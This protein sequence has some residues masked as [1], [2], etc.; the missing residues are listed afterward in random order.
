[1]IKQD[2]NSHTYVHVSLT[3]GEARLGGSIMDLE[4]IKKIAQA[5]IHFEPALQVLIPE[6]RRDDLDAMSNWIDN[7]RFLGRAFSRRKAIGMIESC[8]STREVIELVCPDKSF[9]PWLDPICFEW[10][11][12]TLYKH[13]S[14]EFRSVGTNVGYDMA[15]AWA[16]MALLFVQA[17]LQIPTPISMKLIP[18][19]VREL[20]RFLGLDKLRNLRLV[21]DGKEDDESMQPEIIQFQGTGLQRKL[22]MIL[23]SDEELQ[24]RLARGQLL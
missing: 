4:D 1:V 8:N 20:K 3:R 23:D 17:A 16:E 24:R 10:N 2:I 22:Q 6:S 15:V 14:I 11:F 21:F 7:E 9:R 13:R 18:A 19:N 12:R 5:A